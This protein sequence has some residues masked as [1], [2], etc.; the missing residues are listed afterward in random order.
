MVNTIKLPEWLD[1]YIFQTLQV[2]YCPECKT[3]VALDYDETQLLNY[4]GTYFPRSYAEA[5]HIFNLF[6]Q[7]NKHL[8]D[9]K[10]ELSVF[11]FGCG[12]GGEVFGLLQTVIDNFPFIKKIKILA[13]DGNVGA[14]R[15]LE[16][17]ITKFK[18]IYPLH[19]EFDPLPY[20]INDFSDIHT[21]LSTISAFFDIIISFKSL[22]E[23]VT[24]Q[25][26]GDD[27]PY[28]LFINEFSSKISDTGIICIEDI[29]SHNDVANKWIYEMM[30]NIK[31][32]VSLR[33]I[34]E[35]SDKRETICVSHSQMERDCS[36][37]AWRIFKR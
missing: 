17:A 35:N 1:E 34:G 11:D 19:I 9:G 8:F 20:E 23:F 5:Y 24:K 36:K 22:N 30:N 16:K 21:V 2:S 10:N 4:L 29:T 13:L 12:T 31:D 3:L 28:I 27:N 26:F 6:F 15:I 14:L 25:Q 33:L 37:V 32:H 18:T 7:S